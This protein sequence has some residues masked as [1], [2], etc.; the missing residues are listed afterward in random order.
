MQCQCHWV[1]ATWLPSLNRIMW[2]QCY[3]HFN[4]PTFTFNSNKQWETISDFENSGRVFKAPCQI[5]PYYFLNRLAI[6]KGQIFCHSH[7]KILCTSF[8]NIE[9]QFWTKLTHERSLG[10]FSEENGMLKV[11]FVF[12]NDFW[13]NH[14]NIF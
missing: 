3:G 11:Y 2:K 9:S 4:P 1:F 13:V 5:Q 12:L 14:K 6:Q 7:I 8:F 10:S